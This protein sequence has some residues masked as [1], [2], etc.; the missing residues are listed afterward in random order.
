MCMPLNTN[1][2][3]LDPLS[4]QRLQLEPPLSPSLGALT[5]T[6]LLGSGITT[7]GP[8]EISPMIHISAFSAGWGINQWGITKLGHFRVQS[9][10]C[11]FPPPSLRRLPPPKCIYPSELAFVASPRR[12]SGGVWILPPLPP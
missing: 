3:F 6:T 4:P 1:S 5:T 11:M 10:Q 12:A 2:T 9:E 7:E 8:H